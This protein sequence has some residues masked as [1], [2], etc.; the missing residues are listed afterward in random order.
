MGNF[1]ESCICLKLKEKVCQTYSSILWKI[2]FIFSNSFICYSL[3]ELLS[4]METACRSI[5]IRRL[6]KINQAFIG[7][8]SSSIIINLIFIQF[9]RLKT[10][11]AQF[12]ENSI[13]FKGLK[14]IESNFLLFPFKLLGTII[15][16]TVV[17]N[18]LTSL[19]LHKRLLFWWFLIR[20]L[21]LLIGIS[22][23][24]YNNLAVKVLKSSFILRIKSRS[25]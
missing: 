21:L 5:S 16:A 12:L 13:I 2:N 15:T 11:V 23:L 4:S 14:E 9:R 7:F 6:K 17:F 10:K 24:F 1:T 8:V 18:L 19:V 25:V 20:I 3:G 22:A